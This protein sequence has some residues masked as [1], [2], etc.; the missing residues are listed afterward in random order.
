[1]RF[2]LTKGPTIGPALMPVQSPVTG[3]VDIIGFSG[4]TEL[5]YVA[6]HLAAALLSRPEAEDKGFTMCVVTALDLAQDLLSRSAA[7]S[8]QQAAEQLPVS[9]E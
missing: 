7:A 8:R 2:Q 4:M 6:T 3:A 5:D 1:M 9:L